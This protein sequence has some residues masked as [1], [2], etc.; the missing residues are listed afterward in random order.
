MSNIILLVLLMKLL[1]LFKFSSISIYI[2][3]KKNDTICYKCYY[4]LLTVTIDERLY[5]KNYIFQF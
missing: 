4:I 1:C 3:Y 2:L 5:N